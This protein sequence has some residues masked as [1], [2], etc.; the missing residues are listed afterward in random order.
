M[1]LLFKVVVGVTTTTGE[2]LTNFCTTVVT[3]TVPSSVATSRKLPDETELCEIC[4]LKVMSSCAF[5]A[6]LL[7]LFDG[8]SATIVGGVASSVTGG[9]VTGVVVPSLMVWPGSVAPTVTSSGP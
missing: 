6:T 1:V 3:T 4:S 9:M 8:N 2:P 7:A 5:G